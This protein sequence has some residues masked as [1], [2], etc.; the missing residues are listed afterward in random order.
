MRPNSLTRAIA[1][2]GLVALPAMAET[3]PSAA[4]LTEPVTEP[5]ASEGT[6][7]HDV[8]VSLHDGSLL[9]GK[10]SQETP[11][12]LTLDTTIGQ[13][14]IGRIDIKTLDR[15][16]AKEIR[17]GYLAGD[18]MRTRAFVFPTAATL[19]KGQLVY[20]NYYL[21]FNNLHLGVSDRATVSFGL[22]P[23][24][25]AALVSVG[26]K[27]QLW[28]SPSSGTAAAVGVNMIGFAG[29]DESGSVFLPHGVMSI[30]GSD[31]ATLNL[32]G[33]A[34]ISDDGTAGFFDVS[35]SLRLTDHVTAMGEMIITSADDERQ[36]LPIY[37]L[38]FHN[39]KMAFDLGFWNIPD[40]RDAT[41][42]GTPLA[43]FVFRF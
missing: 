18:P 10:L 36:V 23:L 28:H 5:Q 40:E 2:I 7:G 29:G 32:G 25:D 34:A 41:L 14:K 35:G 11:D 8:H 15:V 9:I 16:A 12:T 1:F 22:T 31:R 43:S 19:P 20:E 13:I 39:G 30:W 33:G 3:E 27:L 21:F 24:P 38:R 42:L 26:S 6:G 4:D 37:G 17:G